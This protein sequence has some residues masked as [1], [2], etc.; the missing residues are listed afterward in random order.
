MKIE[1]TI[2]LT[3]LEKWGVFE[4]IRELIQNGKDAE[5]EFNAPLTVKHREDTKILVI[6]N[7]GCSI[8]HEALLFGHTTK[9][10]RGEL[11]G[12]FGEGLK[13]GI[14]ALVRAGYGVK[15]RSGSEV[16]IPKIERSEKFDADVLVIYIE[17][18][19]QPKERVQ[20]EV[21][22]ITSEE[23]EMMKPCF[24]FLNKTKCKDRIDTYYGALLLHEKDIGKIF[25]KGIF[26][27]HD[28]KLKFGYDLTRDVEI[29]RDRKMVAR[30]DLEWRIR[31]I[32]NDSLKERADLV[33]TYLDMV[34]NNTGDVANLDSYSAAMLPK[35]VQEK[36]VEGF[37]N[38]H[39]INAVPVDTLAD[40]KDVAHLGKNGVLVNKPLK[41]I[42]QAVLG[43]TEEIKASLANEVVKAYGWNELS[44]VEQ[45]NLEGA[46]ALVAKAVVDPLTLG[47]VDVVDFRSETIIGM[48]KGGRILLAK[49]KL[50]DR[51][52][53]LETVVHEVAHRNGG[54]G[55]HQHVATIEKIWSKIVSNLRDS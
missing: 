31:S 42:L 32:W 41:A 35:K 6:E 7:E 28:P 30:C 10:G 25:V 1:L 39:G 49:N 24:L 22:N 12:K 53:T 21:S 33:V 4:G 14:L 38:R 17:S 37:K 26:V 16:W 40:S 54:D 20:V 27:E 48:F 9:A 46:I 3:Y 36:A 11:I 29:D 51:D 44:T 34:E 5:T 23:W 18:G 8:P 2:K 52:L 15:V 43:T 45:T 50:S 19:R 47:N 13:L 55:E